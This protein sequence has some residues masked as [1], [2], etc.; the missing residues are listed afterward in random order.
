MALIN[1]PECAKTVS[2]AA[3]ACPHCGFPI[4]HTSPAGPPESDDD[5]IYSQ[6]LTPFGYGLVMAGGAG[7]VLGSFLPWAQLGIFQVSGI[8]GDG[9]ITAFLGF[10]I[11]VAGY[12]ARTNASHGARILALLGESARQELGST[13]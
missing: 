1:C 13:T 6:L 9:A 4:P 8:D 3:E 10:L 5:A 12:L 2:E 11:L 7:V